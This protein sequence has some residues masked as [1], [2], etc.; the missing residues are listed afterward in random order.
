MSNSHDLPA[1]LTRIAHPA[2][3]Q[4][5]VICYADNLVFSALNILLAIAQNLLHDGKIP[6]SNVCMD[7][8][9]SLM[10]YDPLDFPACAQ[11]LMAMGFTVSA[12]APVIF[13]DCSIQKDEQEPV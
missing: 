12:P 8:M 3:M 9:E 7:T 4:Q 1:Q 11:H 13:F 6:E 10:H 5:P 2:L